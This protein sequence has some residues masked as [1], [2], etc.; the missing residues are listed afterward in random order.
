MFCPEVGGQEGTQEVEGAECQQRQV[1]DP[2]DAAH[3]PL[4]RHPVTAGHDPRHHR[5]EEGDPHL[6]RHRERY[7]DPDR[8]IRLDPGGDGEGGADYGADDDVGRLGAC[9]RGQPHPDQLQGAAHQNAGGQVA[10]DQAHQ[11]AQ[12]HGPVEVGQAVEQV[13]PGEERQHAQQ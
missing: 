2:L 13:K 12:Y 1:V 10:E 8:H 5:E 4:F 7:R 9:Q 11:R 3:I 6:D